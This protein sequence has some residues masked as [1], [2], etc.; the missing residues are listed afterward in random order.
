M[1]YFVRKDQFEKILVILNFSD[2][3][4]SLNIAACFASDIEML[5]SSKRTSLESGNVVTI[6]ANEA[7][8]LKGDIRDEPIK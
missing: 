2:Q 4:K 6:L 8:I 5:L 1:I 3:S 7:I